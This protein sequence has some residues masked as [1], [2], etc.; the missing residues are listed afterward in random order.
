MVVART[1][2]RQESLGSNT[3]LTAAQS[4]EHD[5]AWVV[6]VSAG[7]RIRAASVSWQLLLHVTGYPQYPCFVIVRGLFGKVTRSVHS[8][9]PEATLVHAGIRHFSIDDER[10]GLFG[11]A[12]LYPTATS[13]ASVRVGPHVK[14]LSA[15]APIADGLHR[16]VVISHGSGGSHL[17]YL[18]LAE[19]LA[20][21]GYVVAMPEHTGNNR[22]DAD[23]RA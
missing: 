17:A 14:E 1:V 3:A 7:F 10:G 15:N 23:C 11:A 16:L 22:N 4:E 5:S 2:I 13:L 18:M 6:S 21:C 12:V 8:T 20:T 19:R 9:P